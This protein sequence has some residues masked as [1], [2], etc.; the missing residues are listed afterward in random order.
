M[1]TNGKTDMKLFRYKGISEALAAVITMAALPG[2]AQPPVM[3][4]NTAQK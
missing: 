1:Q 4:A 2:V 3:P